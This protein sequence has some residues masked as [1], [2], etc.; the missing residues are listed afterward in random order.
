MLNPDPTPDDYYRIVKSE[1]QEFLRALGHLTLDWADL[2]SAVRAVLKH[3]AGVSAP[4]A[5]ALFSGTR[6]KTAMNLIGSIAHNINLDPA[7]LSDLEEV[8]PVISSINTMRDFMVHHVDGSMIE[9][10]DR[11]PRFRKLSSV[12]TSSRQG[13]GKAYWISSSMVYDMCHDITQCCWRLLAHINKDESFQ[14]YLD[15]SGAPIPW[16]YKPPQPVREDS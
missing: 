1:H 5:R 6:A 9:Y 14:P 11:D 12:D 7:R 15:P 10:D 2:E 8:F 16:R 3:Y 4:V 13:K